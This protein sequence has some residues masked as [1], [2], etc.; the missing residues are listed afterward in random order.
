M[1]GEIAIVSGSRVP[2]TVVRPHGGKWIALGQRGNEQTMKYTGPKIRLSRRLGIAIT[3]KAG[4]YLE[5]RP[6]RP[7]VHGAKRVRKSSDYGRQLIEKQ[8]LRMQYNISER[9]LRNTYAKASAQSG[10]APVNLMHLLECRLDAVVLRAGLS[11]T[12][13]QARQIVNHGHIQVNGKKVNIPS[14]LCRVG[15]VV[16]VREKSR[17]LEAIEQA[18]QLAPVAPEYLRVNLDEF[19]AELAFL[20]P[21]DQIPVI[22]EV[23]M[24]IE[25]YS[26]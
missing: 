8:K 23:N 5:R 2:V 12:I 14:Y 18:I 17:K 25:F 11:R 15:D 20:P 21:I 6:N 10:S 7:G 4:K 9:Q 26:R 3:P 19:R 1:D 16:T 24:V 22:C 13:Y